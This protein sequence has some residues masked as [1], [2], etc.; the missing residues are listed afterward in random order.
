MALATSPVEPHL[1]AYATKILSFMF[2]PS[3]KLS[4]MNLISGG[5]AL[6]ASPPQ[7]SAATPTVPPASSINRRRV[8]LVF[9]FMLHASQAGGR[10]HLAPTASNAA[11]IAWLRLVHLAMPLFEHGRHA[12]FPRAVMHSMLPA[13]VPYP[14]QQHQDKQQAQQREQAPE[15]TEPEAK[16]L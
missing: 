10:G 3:P 13:P 15:E 12:L 4:S 2:V 14:A 5:R 7:A 11:R 9:S 8:I 16:G 1:L 6:I